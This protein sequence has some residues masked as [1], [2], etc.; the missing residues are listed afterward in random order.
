[1]SREILF[2]AK[3]ENWRELPKEEWWVY[4]DVIHEPIGM[5]IRNMQHG[6]PVRTPIDPETI[7]QYTGLTDKS[8]QRIWENDI[9]SQKTTEHFKKYNPME[10]ER[11]GVVKFGE[12]DWKS[13]WAGYCSV[14]FYI[15]HIKSVSIKPNDYQIG[16]IQEGLNQEDVLNPNYPMEVIGNI[17]DGGVDGKK[18]EENYLY[19]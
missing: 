7:C 3:R 18:S 8:G 1:M 10:W 14:G 12:N 11:Y 19:Q 15:E 17:Y 4:G 5:T 6:M 16:R 9:L 2:K 13:G